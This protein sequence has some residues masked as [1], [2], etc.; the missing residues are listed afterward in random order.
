MQISF[1]GRTVLVTGASTGIGAA[2]AQG[3]ARCGAIVA[4]HYNRSEEQARKIL[5][6]IESEGGRGAL[7]H[8]DLMTPDAPLRL[9]REVE[10]RQGPVD[11][12]VN[13]AGGLLGRRSTGEIT[14]QL[15]EQV[16]QLNLGSIVGMC[17]AVV[18]G[19][20]ERGHGAIVNVSSVAADTGGGPGSSVYAASK[21]AVSTYTRALARELA[22]D[23]IR[24]N[25]LAPGIIATPFH[26]RYTSP[27]AL[28][29]MVATIPMG[30]A[31][32]PGDCVGATLFLAHDGLAGYVT[33]QTV[34][35]N[36]GQYV[37]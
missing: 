11:V 27:E 24:V 29:A 21:G 30:R 18:P 25:T 10:D 35:V 32:Q 20:R 1:D 28:S 17:N 37:S 8:A 5:A 4:V 9:T 31:G 19:M 33:G 23:G 6:A 12:L 2:I 36:G 22:A 13:N 14:R 26:D 16:L 3:F 34:G 7:F 15:Y